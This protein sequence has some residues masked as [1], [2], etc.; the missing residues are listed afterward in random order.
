MNLNKPFYILKN[1][2]KTKINLDSNQIK[3]IE[4]INTY[5]KN[6]FFKNRCVGATTAIN[7]LVADK[8]LSKEYNNILYVSANFQNKKIIF[9]DILYNIKQKI[10][11]GNNFNEDIKLIETNKEIEI[12]NKNNIMFLTY[13]DLPFILGKRFTWIIFD[14][15]AFI[16]DKSNVGCYFNYIENISIISSQNGIN[17]VFAYYYL[18][19]KSSGFN[20]TKLLYNGLCNID[21]N[22]LN[23]LDKLREFGDK[24][25]VKY[26]DDL[27][28]FINKI[29]HKNTLTVE[30]LFEIY[31]E[32]K[33]IDKYGNNI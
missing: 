18:F 11:E 28:H 9:D 5:K 30:D 19:G 14:E 3:L 1:S 22:R 31:K 33:I 29:Y 21:I 10:N 2:R 20:V 7:L 15:M 6:V 16:D 13:N 4:C 26:D 32:I 23:N 12:I 17:N 27:K 25:I 24:I 8:L